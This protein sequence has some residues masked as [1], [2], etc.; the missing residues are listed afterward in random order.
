M[1]V[2]TEKA[3]KNTLSQKIARKDIYS[4]ERGGLELLMEKE[5]FLHYFT[6]HRFQ[7]NIHT[8]MVIF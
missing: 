5:S 8:L 2:Q 3:E 4:G 6:P 1:W 7:N